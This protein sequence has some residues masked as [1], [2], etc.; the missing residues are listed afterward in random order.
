MTSIGDMSAAMMTTT[1]ASD[2]LPDDGPVMGDFRN[3]LTTS[4]TPRFSVLFSA[5]V[6]QV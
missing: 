6:R 5:A 1:T 4:F 3:A 2:V